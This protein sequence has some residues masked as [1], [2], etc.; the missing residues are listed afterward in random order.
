MHVSLVDYTCTGDG[1]ALLE[2][3]QIYALSPEGGSQALAAETLERLLPALRAHPQC[4]SLIA[5][6]N[7]QAIGLAAV[8]R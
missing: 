4:F 8:A 3:M 7:G 6:Q 5:W 1:A 2:L